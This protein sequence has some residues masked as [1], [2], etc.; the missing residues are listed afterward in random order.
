MRNDFTSGKQKNRKALRCVSNWIVSQSIDCGIYYHYGNETL[1][2]LQQWKW[3]ATLRSFTLHY[4]QESYNANLLLGV[5]TVTTIF[6]WRCVLLQMHSS[7]ALPRKSA[8]VV[9]YFL[10]IF[11]SLDISFVC[12][13]I[14]RELKGYKISLAPFFLYSCFYYIKPLTSR[15]SKS[16]ESNQCSNRNKLTKKWSKISVLCNEEEDNC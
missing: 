1:H 3:E 13:T 4:H 6:I 15:W 11:Q 12:F 10:L 16:A 5:M 7:K 14:V 9:R 2:I 8:T